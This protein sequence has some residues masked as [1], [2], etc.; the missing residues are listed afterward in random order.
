M[1][2]SSH[3]NKSVKKELLAVMLIR[4]TMKTIISKKVIWNGRHLPWVSHSLLRDLTVDSFISRSKQ[5][6]SLRWGPYPAIIPMLG[7]AIRYRRVNKNSCLGMIPNRGQGLYLCLP[8]LPW[9]RVNFSILCQ[10]LIRKDHSSLYSE[11]LT[12][13][14]CHL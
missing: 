7:E 4:M 3:L 13:H 5:G 1:T 6:P 8:S 2:H 12:F 11:D 9:A 14:L 10:Q